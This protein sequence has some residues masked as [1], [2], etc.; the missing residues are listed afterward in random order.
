MPFKLSPNVPIGRVK[1]NSDRYAKAWEDPL[2]SPS[3]LI[4]CGD[5][6]PNPKVLGSGGRRKSNSGR[7]IKFC[8]GE[9]LGRTFDLRVSGNRFKSNSDGFS[10]R[11][12]SSSGRCTNT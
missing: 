5:R 2:R 11:L 9:W 12:K 1:S 7:Y 6:V 10:G 3:A 8:K 4:A